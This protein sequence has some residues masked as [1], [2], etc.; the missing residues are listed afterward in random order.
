MWTILTK[1]ILVKFGIIALAH[2]ISS[3]D[4]KKHVKW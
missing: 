2:V 4:T 3:I 1:I